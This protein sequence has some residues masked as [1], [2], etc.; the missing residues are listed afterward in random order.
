MSL[1]MLLKCKENGHGEN[2]NWSWWLKWSWNNLSG[3][4]GCWKM[5]VSLCLNKIFLCENSVGE[6]WHSDHLPCILPCALTSQTSILEARF[7]CHLLTDQLLGLYFQLL[8]CSPFLLLL[9]PLESDVRG[10]S[11]LVRACLEVFTWAWARLWGFC[12]QLRFC[13]HRKM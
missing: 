10:L 13:M 9:F 7:V 5:R 1:K 3:F 4:W 2:L 11:C 12:S 6:Q 8:L